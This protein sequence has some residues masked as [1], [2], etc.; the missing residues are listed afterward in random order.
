MAAHSV[1]AWAVGSACLKAECLAV[2]RVARKAANSVDRK[3]VCWDVRWVVN[4][5][6]WK[7][8]HWDVMKVVHLVGGKVDCLVVLRAAAKVVTRVVTRA[9][10]MESCLVDRKGEMMVDDWADLMAGSTALCSVVMT[11]FLRAV[12]S[13]GD[14]AG[15]R[16]GC[17]A[18]C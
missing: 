14:W 13:V 18:G 17:S 11:A 8:A 15:L 4:W 6:S 5:A 9:E 12:R 10:L 16:G 7:A 3:A 2:R 1:V